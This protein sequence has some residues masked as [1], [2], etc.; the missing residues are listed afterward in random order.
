M[1]SFPGTLWCQDIVIFPHWRKIY[2]GTFFQKAPAH[3]CGQVLTSGPSALDHWPINI[4]LSMCQDYTCLKTTSSV[5]SQPASNLGTLPAL[6]SLSARSTGISH[7]IRLQ[8]P[9]LGENCQSSYFV[10][11]S[12]HCFFATQTTEKQKTKTS[13]II[14]PSSPANVT[15]PQVPEEL[16]LRK[17]RE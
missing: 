12:L 6:T 11:L 14:N 5:V 3:K 17:C 8:V 1:P 4:Y 2:L 13:C 15:N 16:P 10:H 7:N 9:A